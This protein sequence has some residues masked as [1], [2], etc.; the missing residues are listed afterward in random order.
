MSDQSTKLPEPGDDALVKSYNDVAYTSL[1]D[2][3]RHPARLATIGTLFGLDVAPLANC[4]ILE[5]ACGDGLNIVPIA[6]TLPNATLVG[7]DFAAR[8]VARAQAMARDLGLSNI[9]LLQLDL[10]EL[11]ADLGNFDYI[12]AHGLYSWIPANVRAHV[13]PLI[14]RHL[15]PNGVAFVSYNTLPGCHM[16]RTVWEML[17]YH[18]RDPPGMP[19]KVAAARSLL[20]MVATPV[21]TARR[22]SACHARGSAQRQ[23]EQ[24]RRIGARRHERAQRSRLLS[25][26]HGRRC[27]R[28]IDLLSRGP[29]RHDDGQAV[30]RRKCDGRLDRST[31]W[32]ANNI[33]TSSTSAASASHCYATR[34][35]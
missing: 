31:G 19:A 14:K 34:M 12:I 33:S 23:R 30:S 16:R 32:R 1:P 28:R 15:A 24:R 27:E 11:P 5:L 7:F 6:A 29:S 9:E 22:N 10:R 20:K 35:R 2:A 18:T 4:R 17:K 25:R 13:L 21:T 3:A 8:P 26:I